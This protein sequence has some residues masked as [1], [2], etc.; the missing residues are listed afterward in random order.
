MKE[1]FTFADLRSDCCGAGLK[2]ISG[3]EGTR[4][5]TCVICVSCLKPCNQEPVKMTAYIGATELPP[6]AGGSWPKTGLSES[7]PPNFKPRWWRK[8]DMYRVSY[9][10]LILNVLLGILTLSFLLFQD[11]Y[12]DI[13]PV[14]ELSAYKVRS[15]Q[16][17]TQVSFEASAVDRRLWS[18][19]MS[20]RSFDYCLSLE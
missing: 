4:F 10:V 8:V 1:P 2:V 19:E 14:N 13:T 17:A 3:E 11:S 7:W 12:S 6:K 20:R 18:T 5:Y 15:L 16:C 9:S